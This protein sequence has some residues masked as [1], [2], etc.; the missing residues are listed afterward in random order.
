MN[1][2]TLEIEKS[3]EPT[4]DLRP[5]PEAIPGNKHHIAP[6]KWVASALVVAGLDVSMWFLLSRRSRAEARQQPLS[7]SETSSSFATLSPEQ[8]AAI[9]IEV[10]QTRTLQ[11][12]VNAPG[13]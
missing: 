7:E 6:G 10:T 4:A 1:E 8:Q 3:D 12:D 13:K 5:P 11:G 2:A 9:A